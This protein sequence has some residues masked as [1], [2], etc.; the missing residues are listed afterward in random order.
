[1][2]TT[3]KSQQFLGHIHNPG[4]CGNGNMLPLVRVRDPPQDFQ[5]AL[6]ACQETGEEIA[7]QAFQVFDGSTN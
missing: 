1:M 3:R 2:S 6:V 4:Q 5:A 7:V